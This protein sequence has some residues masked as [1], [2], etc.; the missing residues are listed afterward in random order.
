MHLKTVIFERDNL[1]MELD[2]ALNQIEKLEEQVQVAVKAGGDEVLHT[3]MEIRQ[4]PYEDLD[5]DGG[6]AALAN[7]QDHTVEIA[8]SP[9]E[10]NFVGGELTKK[11]QGMVMM[12]PM[13]QSQS[14]DKLT[15]AQGN[16]K[17]NLGLHNKNV[18]NARAKKNIVKMGIPALDLST[19]KNVKDYKDWY[20]YS[21]KL[22]NAIR[23]LREKNEAL[24][25]ERDMKDLHMMKLE[26]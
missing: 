4:N 16:M 2:D 18:G 1:Q 6:I 11:R 9:F 10:D 7:K 14:N 22:E 13:G 25:N 24:E 23:L 15:M 26:K 20:G 3:V 5:E 21:Q 12:P 17:M 8:A 19:L